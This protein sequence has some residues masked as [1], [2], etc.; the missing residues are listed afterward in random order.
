MSNRAT[1]CFLALLMPGSFVIV[2]VLVYCFVC[3]LK[4]WEE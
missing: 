1:D 4:G 2:G 3:R